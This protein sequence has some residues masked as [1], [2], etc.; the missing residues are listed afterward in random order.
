MFTTAV[1]TATDPTATDT[2][3]N[4]TFSDVVTA[5]LG[6]LTLATIA[7]VVISLVAAIL[8]ARK[9]GYSHW[10]GVIAVAVPFVGLVFVLMFA[11]LK[12]PALK[13]RDAAL[14]LLKKNGLSIAPPKPTTPASGKVQTASSKDLKKPDAP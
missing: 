7:Y 1:A 2:T 10:L 3:G 14:A 13:E 6:W 12:W 4:L 8:I 9:A 5:W 11:F